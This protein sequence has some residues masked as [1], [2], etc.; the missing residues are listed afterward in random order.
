MAVKSGWEAWRCCAAKFTLCHPDRCNAIVFIL[1][2]GWTCQPHI[3]TLG[4]DS[5]VLLYNFFWEV[6]GLFKSFDHYE[7]D[8]GQSVLHLDSAG[9][10]VIWTTALLN[11]DIEVII[12]GCPN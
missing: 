6:A 1:P 2:F 8:S 3:A 9:G 4:G 5:I 10:D 11:Y 12:D 7:K